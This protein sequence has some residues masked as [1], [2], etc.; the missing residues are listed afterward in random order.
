MN[1]KEKN[2]NDFANLTLDYFEKYRKQKQHVHELEKKFKEKHA[3]LMDLQLEIE[4][5]RSY[6]INMQGV[7]TIMIENNCDPVEAKLRQESFEAGTLWESSL[8]II[9]YDSDPVKQVNWNPPI[10]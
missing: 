3:Q 8:N 9:R 4:K 1:D 7:I 5:E 2:M 10:R 6:A